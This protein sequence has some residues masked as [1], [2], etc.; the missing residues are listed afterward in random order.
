LA[1]YLASRNRQVLVSPTVDGITVVYDALTESQEPRL[2]TNLG[3]ELSA[4]FDCV[5]LAALN[6]DDEMLWLQLHDD[7]NLIDQYNSA[8]G[9]F[10]EEPS[11]VPEGGDAAALC[12]AFDRMDATSQ[13]KRVLRRER[14]PQGYVFAS[15]RHSELAEALGLRPGLVTTGYRYLT[16]GETPEGFQPM[17]FIHTGPVPRT[18]AMS[19]QARGHPGPQGGPQP[20]PGAPGGGSEQRQAGPGGGHVHIG[21]SP[22]GGCCGCLL[23]PLLIPLGLLLSA[24]SALVLSRQAEQMSDRE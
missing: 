7:G 2:L 4:Q 15:K 11:S 24:Y 13:V 14:D 5:S 16:H 10:D 19:Q 22:G 1:E 8:P 20:P 21:P 18:A 9:W 23:A 6:H 3:R 17:D 12:A